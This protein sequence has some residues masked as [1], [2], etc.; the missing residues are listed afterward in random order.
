ME[1]PIRNY[2]L[3]KNKEPETGYGLLKKE[4]SFF[5]TEIKGPIWKVHFR[6]ILFGQL[7]NYECTKECL[8]S[9]LANRHGLSSFKFCWNGILVLIDDIKSSM[10]T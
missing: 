8:T 3:G 2:R 1:K 4:T 6:I 5:R 7:D 10:E 9:E